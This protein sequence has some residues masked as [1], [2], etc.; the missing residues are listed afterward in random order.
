MAETRFVSHREAGTSWEMGP[1]LRVRRDDATGRLI[2]I[3]DREWATGQWY[4]VT[5]LDDP[6]DVH[7]YVWMGTR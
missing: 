4:D 7:V 6:A 3:T 1:Y 2:P 5:S